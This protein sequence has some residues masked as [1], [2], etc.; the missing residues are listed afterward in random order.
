MP[1]Q[2][3]QCHATFDENG[4]CRGAGSKHMFRM[5]GSE[6]RGDVVGCGGDFGRSDDMTTI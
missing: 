3:D 2:C 1:T 6:H 5:L 4:I